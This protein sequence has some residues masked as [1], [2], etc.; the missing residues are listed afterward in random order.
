M[1]R[2]VAIFSTVHAG[3]CPVV[4]SADAHGHIRPEATLTLGAGHPLLLRDWRA[5]AL[6][7]RGA[8]MVAAERLIDGT[9]IRAGAEQ[10][11]LRL[12]TLSFDAPHVIY[13]EGVCAA[14][15]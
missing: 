5:K 2:L 1:V 6:Y 15:G 13:A 3:V 11:R 7:G 14:A 10:A 4:V 12:F 9:Y 8:A